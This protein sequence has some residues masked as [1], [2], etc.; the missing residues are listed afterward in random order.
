MVYGVR[1]NVGFPGSLTVR[2][3]DRTRTEKLGIMGIEDQPA[4]A[5]DLFKQK[6]RE[7]AKVGFGDGTVTAHGEVVKALAKGL[8]SARRVIPKPEE[9]LQEQRQRRV[10]EGRRVS[11]NQFRR[12]ER[13]RLEVNAQTR[14]FVNQLNSVAGAAQARLGG[15][16][17]AEEP[18]PDEGRATLELNGQTFDF[19]RFS[20]SPRLDLLA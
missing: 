12:L 14:T 4:S 1:Q 5:A 3:L 2:G 6:T 15:T 9:L 11:R 20:N 7:V 10:E 8:R 18:P 17:P 19:P 16:G 13:R